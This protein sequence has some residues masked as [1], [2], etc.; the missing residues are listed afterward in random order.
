MVYLTCLL[1]FQPSV[2]PLFENFFHKITNNL[3]TKLRGNFWV[4]NL[5]T[6]FLKKLLWSV[7]VWDPTS[8]HPSIAAFYLKPFLCSSLRK[9]IPWKKRKGLSWQS[10]G[11]DSALPAEKKKKKKRKIYRQTFIFVFFS[12]FLSLLHHLQDLSPS[13]RDQTCS[14]GSE[15]TEFQPLDCQGIP[16]HFRLDL[17]WLITMMET[18]YNNSIQNSKN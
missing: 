11:W 8:A 10:S 16:F 14:L 6:C 15:S 4:L 13:S 18:E 5:N 17:L 2:Q 9:E 3:V 1:I 7:W 12:Q